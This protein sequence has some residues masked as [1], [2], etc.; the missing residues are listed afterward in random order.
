MAS[1]TVIRFVA[2]AAAGALLAFGG[3]AAWAQ[4]APVA[5]ARPHAEARAAHKAA[6]PERRLAVSAKPWT[7]DFAGMLE[8]RVI[9]IESP[10]SRSL[11]F[12]DRGRERGIGV[13][14]VRDF[15]RWINAKYASSWAK[16][17]LTVYMG[18]ATRDR[19]LPDL[20]DGLADIAIGEPHRHRRTAASGRLRRA[21]R[22]AR[23]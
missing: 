16:R 7:G 17:P 9:R 14:L 8:R 22:P 21:R 13:E 4:T 6:P 2:T 5:K 23:G 18:A 11:Y 15:E 20:N 3:P 19:L 12:I 10:Y 1:T